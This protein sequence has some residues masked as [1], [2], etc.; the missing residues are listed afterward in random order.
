VALWKDVVIGG[1]ATGHIRMFDVKTGDIRIEIAAHAR[2][3]T[4]LDVA[5]K[6]GLVK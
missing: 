2:Y 6:A 5:W 3:I 4:A 1:Y